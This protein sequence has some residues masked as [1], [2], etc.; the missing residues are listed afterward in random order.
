MLLETKHNWFKE[1]FILFRRTAKFFNLKVK[2]K[3][4]VIHEKN[5]I[6]TSSHIYFELALVNLEYKPLTTLYMDVILGTKLA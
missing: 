5:Y 4:V 3:K 1:F 2:N 6:L